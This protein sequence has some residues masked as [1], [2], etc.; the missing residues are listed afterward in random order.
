M[1]WW[2]SV[3]I[4]STYIFKF[5]K[6]RFMDFQFVLVLLL[7]I[8]I[9]DV[10]ARFRNCVC[11]SFDSFSTGVFNSL[12]GVCDK[13]PNMGN[14]TKLPRASVFTEAC[15]SSTACVFRFSFNKGRTRGILLV[16]ISFNWKQGQTP[17][18][19]PHFTQH[20]WLGNKSF[21]SKTDGFYCTFALKEEKAGCD[22]LLCR[23]IVCNNA[24]RIHV[25]I[26]RN[27]AGRNRLQSTHARTADL[28][29]FP[30]SF[31]PGKY[32]V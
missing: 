11:L 3:R 2:I 29:L 7:W 19:V 32:C 28:F 27:V 31:S 4:K 12:L 30:L 5:L 1:S 13:E 23:A 6:L 26:V 8:L 15:I 25:E 10:F 9:S 16:F 22:W 14:Q 24:D 20:C 18:H 17:Q 21:N